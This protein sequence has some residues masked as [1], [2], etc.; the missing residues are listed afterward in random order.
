MRESKDN[1]NDAVPKVH[2]SGYSDD[3]GEN[4]SRALAVLDTGRVESEP[5]EHVD[6]EDIGS[7]LQQDLEPCTHVLC[8]V[9]LY[10]LRIQVWHCSVRCGIRIA[11]QAALRHGVA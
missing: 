11:N 10:L 8:A 7:R 6:G 4:F 5:E 2:Y 3:C 9:T 1:G